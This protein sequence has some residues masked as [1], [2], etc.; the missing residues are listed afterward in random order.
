MRKRAAASPDVD[1]IAGPDSLE[2]RYRGV[3]K[4]PWGKFAA[5]IRD[6]VKKTRIWLGTFNSSEAAAAAYDAAAV[7]LRGHKAK[8][9]F[10]FPPPS[11]TSRHVFHHH[12]PPRPTSSSMSSTVESF[13]GPRRS[14]P[15]TIGKMPSTS[16]C[17]SRLRPRVLSGDDD[18][19]SDCG[20]SSSV[21]DDAGRVD[22]SATCRLPFPF[23]L[24]LLPTCDDVEGE[25]LMCCT[26]LR[27]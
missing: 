15:A 24:N 10:P 3:R 1:G 5:E 18:C 12:P 22:A 7:S 21:V 23:D 27:L 13:S 25:D 9:N 19:H 20:S 16:S 17:A 4:R 6:P 26:A 2:I 8:T 11:V 14:V